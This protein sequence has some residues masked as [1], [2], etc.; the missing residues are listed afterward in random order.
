MSV[1]ILTINDGEEAL[2]RVNSNRPIT[3][4]FYG[5]LVT[6]YEKDGLIFQ[7]VEK[8]N[9]PMDMTQ[10]A[11]EPEAGSEE[12]TQALDAGDTQLE[13]MDEVVYEETQIERYDSPLPTLTEERISSHCVDVM[14]DAMDRAYKYMTK[15][16]LEDIEEIQCDLFNEN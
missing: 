15:L 6:V 13:E 14:I 4:E 10:E 9:E 11:Y 3:L 8:Q 5:H 12:E 7:R 1:R 2:I 16:D